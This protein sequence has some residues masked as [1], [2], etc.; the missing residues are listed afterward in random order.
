MGFLSDVKG[1]TLLDVSCGSGLFTRRFLTSQEFK[2]VIAIDFSES[3]LRETKQRIQNQAASQYIDDV[4][5]IRADVGRLP[6]KSSSFSAIYSGAA[7]HCWPSP[8]QAFTEISRILKPGGVFVASTFLFFPFLFEQLVGDEV[9]AQAK[10]LTS[11]I[12]RNPSFNYLIERD[13]KDLAESVGLE[14]FKS[15]KVNRF[16]L[17]SVSKPQSS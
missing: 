13:L 1:G 12:F 11:N 3:M 6:F 10:R 17:F 4:Q 7:I 15:Y 8:Q 5:L 9:V 14:N 16:I 2:K